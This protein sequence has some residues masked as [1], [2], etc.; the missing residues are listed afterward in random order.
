MSHACRSHDTNV[1]S[2]MTR[3]SF[4]WPPPDDI[5]H[6]AAHCISLQRTMPH[7]NS[8]QHIAPHC[9]T[10]QHTATHCNTMQHSATHC[11]NVIHT[12]IHRNTMQRT[13]THCHTGTFCWPPMR[14]KEWWCANTLYRAAVTNI[15][16]LLH[17]CDL[18]VQVGWAEQ[19]SA[20]VERDSMRERSG[21]EQIWY[22]Q[23]NMFDMAGRRSHAHIRTLSATRGCSKRHRYPHTC[24]TNSLYSS[25][26]KFREL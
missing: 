24:K 9:N 11:Y 25:L 4:C 12:A 23:N 7:C 20:K 26:N 19:R 1:N 6:D 18:T 22:Q 17:N 8:L 15:W 2:V 10:L 16:Q 21:W 13:A 5:Q 14:Y 3:I